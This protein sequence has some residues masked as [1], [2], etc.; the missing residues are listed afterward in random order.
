[1]TRPDRAA[2]SV[3]PRSTFALSAFLVVLATL[4]VGLNRYSL[5]TAFPEETTFLQ[6]VWNRSIDSV[7]YQGL[8]VGWLACVLY[9]LTV[10]VV[11]SLWTRRG[12]G[13]TVQRGVTAM[14]GLPRTLPHPGSERAL[15]FRAA[16]SPLR[17]ATVLFPALGFIGTVIGVSLAIGGLNDVI[18]TGET[19]ALL[20]GLRIAFDT[21]LLG[22]VASATLTVILYL[23]DTHAMILSSERTQ[24]PADPA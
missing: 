4:A 16:L 9:G 21:T 5:L 13:G 7:Y 23:C 11:F 24:P 3:R 17:E 14:T 6:G 10:F 8:I 22:L 15:I 1:M 2:M 19:A 12:A 18:E 20:D